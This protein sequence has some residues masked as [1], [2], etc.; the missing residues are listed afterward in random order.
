MPQD[1]PKMAPRRPQDGPRRPKTP[2][3]PSKTLPSHPKPPP[4][5]DFGTILRVLGR[6]VE[7]FLEEFAVQPASSKLFSKKAC[8]HKFAFQKSQPKPKGL[9]VFAAGVGNSILEVFGKILLSNMPP[10]TYFRKKPAS[11]NSLSKKAS[12]KNKG[13]AVFAAGV[14]NPPA[15]RQGVARACSKS[16]PASPASSGR[17]RRPTP[18]APAAG[19]SPE[20]F[21]KTG[22]R[23]PQDASKTPPRRIFCDHFW[24]AFFDASWERFSLGFPSQLGLPKP[25]KSS[26]NR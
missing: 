8:L 4:D 17:L 24:L 3:D 23:R 2:Q 9:A 15:P 6:F 5:N 1:A 16:Y 26:K 18:Q 13:P 10:Q 12:L 21:S 22:S 20:P 19:G 25:P 7:D 11:T 14:G